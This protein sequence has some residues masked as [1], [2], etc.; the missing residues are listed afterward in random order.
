CKKMRFTTTFLFPSDFLILP[1][2]IDFSAAEVD[3]TSAL[4]K[5]ISLKTPLLSS[6]MDTVTESDMAIGM[7]LMGGMGFVHYNCTPE[8]QAAE[9]RRVKKYE[10]GFIQN[11]VTLGPKASV[12]DVI[13]VKQ[14]YGFSGIPITDNGLPTG[15]LIGLVSSRDFDF[16]TSEESNTLLEEVMTTRD[17]LI[18]A[19]T[20]VTLQEANNI[21]SQSKKG[22][23]PIVDADDRL[24]SLI[25]RTDLKKNR[26]FPLASKDERKQL[27]CGAAIST[28]EEDKHRLELLVEAGV[29]AVI[30]VGGWGGCCYTVLTN[31]TKPLDCFVFE[32]L[33]FIKCS[34][35]CSFKNKPQPTESTPHTLT[36]MAVG[37]P[38]ATAVYK[39]SEYARRFSVPV[40][41]DGGIQNVGHITKALALGASTVMMGSL[42]AATTESPGEYFYSDGIRLKKYR[43]MG[44]VD[45]MEGSKAT[46]YNLPA[47]PMRIV[48]TCLILTG[49]CPA[50]ILGRTKKYAQVFKKL[51]LS[52]AL[53]NLRTR[54]EKDKIRVAQGVSGAVQDKGSVHTF[55]PYLIAGI[56]HGCQDIG[57]RSM[58]MLRSMMYS[59][60]LKFE[61]R[62]SSAQIEGGVHGLH[63][64]YRKI[65]K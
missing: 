27:L 11:P 36:V 28:R 10:Q 21:L 57:S 4:T 37:R 17:K 9:V 25:A 15:K 24:V 7:A 5:K 63:S 33:Q 6:P 26:E 14:M 53:T 46:I 59:G 41:A 16:L 58:P 49:L 43:G 52:N 20:S 61:R 18:T 3:L 30:L 51:D 50:Q 40:I 13:E 65:Y 44:S 2:F 1:G 54:S 64:L 12:K 47:A 34:L 42:L 56:Q 31:P 22:K 8:I 29:D 23:L 62:S 48:S 45:A 19:D 39:V 55:L 32:I 35:K 60:E 38:Q